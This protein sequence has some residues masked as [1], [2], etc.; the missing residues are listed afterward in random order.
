VQSAAIAIALQSSSS[1]LVLNPGPGFVLM[2][3][4]T[5]TTGTT[6]VM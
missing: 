6:F 1:N 2:T 3:I 4:L 5:L